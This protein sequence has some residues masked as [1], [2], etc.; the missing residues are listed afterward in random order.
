MDNKDWKGALSRFQSALVLDPR[1]AGDLLGFGGVRAPSGRFC[2]CAGQLSEVI[3]YDPGSRHAKD[4]TKALK[5]PEIAN[6][7]NLRTRRRGSRRSLPGRLSLYKIAPAPS[8][9]DSFRKLL[10][11]LFPTLKRGLNKH[12]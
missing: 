2:G 4:A 5:E 8:L 9:R 12:A 6:A 7:K 10:E 1:G 3:D 11:S